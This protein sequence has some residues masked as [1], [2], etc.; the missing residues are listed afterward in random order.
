MRP[1]PP[2]W[3]KVGKA[4]GPR[5]QE[6]SQPGRAAAKEA[7]EELVCGGKS[8][9]CGGHWGPVGP[10]PGRACPDKGHSVPGFPLKGRPSQVCGAIVESGRVGGPWG[11]AS[12]PLSPAAGG[13][14]SRSQGQG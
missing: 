14:A 13:R 5:G 3:K 11:R 8:P 6:E 7:T 2:C 4:E 12:V 1:S 10:S 9:E